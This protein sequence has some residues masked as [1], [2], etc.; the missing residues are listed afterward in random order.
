ML[1]RRRLIV[2]VHIRFI[3][4]DRLFKYGSRSKVGLRAPSAVSL[5][6]LRN[7]FLQRDQKRGHHV[8]LIRV[9]LETLAHGLLVLT[10]LCSG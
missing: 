6:L 8:K 1:Q 4:C 9:H 3:L 10:L 2:V 7:P 5:S